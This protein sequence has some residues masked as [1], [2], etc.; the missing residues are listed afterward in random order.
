V[1][2]DPKSILC[3]GTWLVRT[4]H[5]MEYVT[6]FCVR[7]ACARSCMH[8]HCI[9]G[10]FIGVTRIIHMGGHDSCVRYVIHSYVCETHV[11]VLVDALYVCHDSF[12]LGTWLIHV[13]HITHSHVGHDSFT[14]VCHD[15]FT[16]VC[17]D[18][19]RCLTW[20]IHTR[21][22]EH[23]THSHL[24]QM[25][26]CHNILGMCHMNVWNVPCHVCV[27]DT[28]TPAAKGLEVARI[29]P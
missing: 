24:R 28:F 21:D 23:S 4:W 12:K 2:H 16:C 25:W 9:C 15:S 1:R 14:R 7:G 29:Y 6:F 11:R 10:A 26:M 5:R 8:K 27:C 17:H 18:S 20:H 13:C 3:H 22:M 19:S